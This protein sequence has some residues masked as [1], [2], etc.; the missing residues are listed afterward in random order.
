MTIVGVGGTLAAVADRDF[1]SILERHLPGGQVHQRLA[2]SVFFFDA[3]GK[4]VQ[5][6]RGGYAFVPVPF[7]LGAGNKK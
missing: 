5:Y 3:G 6:A 7:F 1:V 4:A 2:L